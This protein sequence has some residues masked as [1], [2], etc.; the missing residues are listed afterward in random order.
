M[1]SVYAVRYRTYRTPLPYYRTVY[2]SSGRGRTGRAVVPAA[3]VH[4]RQSCGPHRQQ[5][6]PHVVSTVCAYY[7]GPCS[8]WQGMTDAQRQ[9]QVDQAK[10]DEKD[11]P[12]RLSA[13][14][15]VSNALTHAH[16]LMNSSSARAHA[17]RAQRFRRVTELPRLRGMCSTLSMQVNH[18][19]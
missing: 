9:R 6:H 7:L 10:R 13:V 4:R 2:S 3:T 8:P 15:R 11:A 1:C 14:Y 17:A 12:L 16:E 18:L 19:R 5:P